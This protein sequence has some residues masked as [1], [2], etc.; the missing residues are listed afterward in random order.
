MKLE[1]LIEKLEPH[2]Y[3]KFMSQVMEYRGAV[4][5]E[6]AQDGFMNYVKMIY[7]NMIENHVVHI[8]IF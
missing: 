1:Q 3:E 7:S 8:K 6:R 4:E 2:E 5:R